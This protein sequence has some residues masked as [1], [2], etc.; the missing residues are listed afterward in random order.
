LKGKYSTAEGRWSGFGPYYATFP[1]DFA[2]RYIESSTQKGEIVL[3]PFAGRGTALFAAGLLGRTGVGVEIN[4]VGW[5]FSSVK[6]SP[7]AFDDVMRRLGKFVN[8]ALDLILLPRI[9]RL[10]KKHFFR[11]AFLPESEFLSS[12][13]AK[14]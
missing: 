14:L 6:S 11:C 12:M 7:A 9:H 5:L 1:S 13:H 10:R 4:P 3:D 8:V 2:E